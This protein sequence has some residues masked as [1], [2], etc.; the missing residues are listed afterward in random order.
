MMK[1]TIQI[2][3]ALLAW[4]T[5]FAACFSVY[6]ALASDEAMELARKVYDRPAGK[7]GS[8]QV[9]MTL[10]GK[11]KTD[12]V[13]HL[14]V[15]RLDLGGGERWNL[16]RFS[17]PADVEDTGLLTLDHPGD[18]SEQWIYLPALKR[19]R[20]I[21]SKRKG[22]RF[23]GSDFTYEDLRD[24]EPE[25][26]THT[27]EGK[28]KVG[29]LECVKLVSVPVEKSNSIY[30][31][32][33]SCIHLKTL[34]PL[35]VELFEKGGKKPA[36]RMMARKLKKIQGYWTVLESTMYDLKTGNQTR[37]STE[38]I[39]FDLGIPKDLFSK[40]GLSDPSREQRF[41]Q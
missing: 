26:D 29:G 28:E 4:L 24:R 32:R 14:S 16:M 17:L 2:W 37:L 25:M 30:S 34:T 6:P 22:G 31:K 39:K 7:D 13:R 35:K 36:K 19:V 23:V 5:L 40:Q 9:V 12:R 20:I 8:S 38:K 11:N 10:K 3:P 18:D 1:K 15:Y 41:T 27:I 21:S 33:E